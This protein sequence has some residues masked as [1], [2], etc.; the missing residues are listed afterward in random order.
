MAGLEVDAVTP[1]APAFSGVVVG[2]IAAIEQHPDADKLRICQVAGHPDGQP[3][4]VVCGA[5]NAR[6]GLKIPFATLGAELPGIKI[7][8]AKLRGVESFGMLCAEQELGLAE[9]SQGLWELPADAPVGTCIREYLQLDDSIIEVDLTP[10]RGDCLGMIGLAREVSA[11]TN[12]ALKS[13]EINQIK[14][15]FQVKREVKISA[16][17]HCARYVGRVIQNINTGCATPIWMVERLRRAGVRSIDP[18]VDVTNYVLLTLGQP[19]HAFDLDVVEGGIDVRLARK[20]EKLTLL[21]GQTVELQPD[22][23]VIADAVKPLALAGI[24]GGAAS[25]VTATTRNVLL[26]SAWFNPVSM[27]GK[28]R[29]YGLHTDASHRFERG[30]DFNIQLQAIELATKL[31]LDIVGGEAG[32][33]VHVVSEERLPQRQSVTLTRQRLVQYLGVDLPEAEVTSI[34]SRLGFAPAVDTQ[35]WTIQPPSWRYDIAIEQDLIEEVARVYGYNRLPSRS[36]KA[37]LDLTGMPETALA[38]DVPSAVLVARGY[39][40]V[41]SYSFISPEWQAMFEPQQPSVRLR[42]PISADMSDMRASLLPSL[43]GTLLH[44][45]NRQQSRVRLF[46]L[47][48][49]FRTE[50]GQLQQQPVMAG[51]LYGSRQPESW[52]ASSDKVDFFDL[53]GDLQ[54]LLART[55]RAS[56]FS[57]EKAEHP[58]LHL[59]QSALVRD[60]ERAVGWMGALHPELQRKLG[61]PETVLVFEIERSALQTA[62][63]PAFAPISRFPEVRRDLA[64]V[65]DRA[66]PVAT[67]CNTV[68]AQAGECLTDLKVFDVYVGEHIESNR[69][70]VALGLTFQHASRTLNEAEIVEW[71]DSVLVALQERHGATLRN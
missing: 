28:A 32:A 55:G 47:G 8:Q 18:V 56:H 68:R 1:V 20:A 44:N 16:P 29:N 40:E 19:M 50:A 31:L 51:L 62:N 6:L 15:T 11:L 5:A 38:S 17:E 69:K 22:T 24:M 59:G 3:K 25:A 21:D 48:L 57:F 52:T 53:K 39:R 4:Q 14:E 7:K 43:V 58:A 2:E 34:L 9:S 13:F 27:A 60:G 30:V 70:S 35:G 66:L 64:L 45:L 49:R 23:L 10:N 54:A 12:S 67:L 63:Q 65:V 46:E 61:I 42:N 71:V 37:G 33:I 26:E 41:I 36:Y